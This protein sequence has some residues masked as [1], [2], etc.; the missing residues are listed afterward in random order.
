VQGDWGELAAA[1]WLTGHGRW[2]VAICTRGGN[3]SWSGMTKR[4]EPG[5]CDF[6]FALAGDGRQWFIPTS[7]IE[8]TTAICLGGPK[9][10]GFEIEPGP[11][12]PDQTIPKAATTIACR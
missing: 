4:F 7:A 9:Y 5:R 11:R 1:L 12:I 2:L 10:E 6:V 3:Q 8:G